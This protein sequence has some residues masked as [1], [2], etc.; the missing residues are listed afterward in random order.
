VRPLDGEFEDGAGRRYQFPPGRPNDRGYVV[1][2]RAE[3]AADA[4]ELGDNP[5]DD[6][7][8]SLPGGVEA[9][10]RLT[11]ERQRA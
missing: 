10:R 9:R 7:D 4:A 1:P 11:G 6:V 2:W 8:W 5:E 3:W